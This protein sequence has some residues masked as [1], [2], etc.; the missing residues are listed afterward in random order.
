MRMFMDVNE[1]QQAVPKNLRNT[2]NAD[3]LYASDD[4]REQSRALKL[5]LAQRLGEDK[6]SPLYGRVQVGEDTKTPL[7]CLTIDAVARGL[8]RGGFI[9]T[10]TKSEVKEIGTFYRGT[11]DATC[12]ALFEYLALGIGHVREHLDVQHKLGSAEGGFVFINNGIES[13]IRLLGD[14]V[15]HLATQGGD[16]DPRLQEPRTLY[17]DAV[18]YLDSM[19][20]H[21]AG[22]EPAEALQY[23]QL[24]GSGAGTKY[25]RRLQQAVTEARPEFNPP[26]LDEYLRDEEKQFNDESRDMIDALEAFM[27]QDVRKRLQD[28]YGAEWFKSGVPRNLRVEA[29]KMMVER[30]A[31]RLPGQEIG[32]WDCLYFVNYRE[33]M[34][35]TQELWQEL[36]EKRY[37]P[38]GDENKPGGRKGR[39]SWIAMVGDLRN[40]VAHQR[41]VSVDDHDFLITLHTWLVKGQTDNDL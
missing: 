14:I 22:L 1:N 8:D 41:T 5:V 32:E 25:W 18:P 28:K 7:R 15:V 20:D 23:R 12:E 26:G 2:L 34:I 29:G 27:K 30:N 16:Y 24:Y 36:F 33:V 21:L 11:N 13:I 40:D 4:L 39:T 37:T 31:D 38:P 19:I 10:F 6:V 35:Q 17:Q 3:L 9:G